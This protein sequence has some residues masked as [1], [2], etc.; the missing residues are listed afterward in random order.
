M[1]DFIKD[2]FYKE[3]FTNATII[4]CLG[5]ENCILFDVALAMGDLEAIVD[6]Y[7]SVMKTLE[8]AGGV[9]NETLDP[10]TLA[11]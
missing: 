4:K 10:R 1:V 3:A 8:K 11:D 6:S 7:Y 9:A 2:L 5:R